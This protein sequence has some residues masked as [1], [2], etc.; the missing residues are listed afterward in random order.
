MKKDNKILDDLAKLAGSTFT[1]AVNVKN[2]I[3][4]HTEIFLFQI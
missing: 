3:Q 1:G 2:E 4:I